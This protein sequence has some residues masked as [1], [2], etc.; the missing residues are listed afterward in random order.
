[1]TPL[2]SLPLYVP[3][4][5][6][7]AAGLLLLAL[8][9]CSTTDPAEVRRQQLDVGCAKLTRLLT[10]E[11]TTPL[12]RVAALRFRPAAG[13]EADP[14]IVDDISGALT[15]ALAVNGKIGATVDRPKVEQAIADSGLTEVDGAL[16]V[17]SVGGLLEATALITG[18]YELSEAGDEMTLRAELRSTVDGMT[19]AEARVQ[20]RLL[21]P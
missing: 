11:V 17:R 5:R 19:M 13:G 12:E 20:V 21:A 10:A 18:T 7:L 4:A 16:A 9:A 8:A 14:A 6:A 3:R 1:M 15:A 2:P